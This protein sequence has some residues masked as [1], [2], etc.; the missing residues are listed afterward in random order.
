MK[1]LSLLTKYR[2]S[3]DFHRIA[4]LDSDIQELRN[5]VRKFADQSVAPL[6]QKVD[7]EDKFPHH[8]WK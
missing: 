1:A 2:F 8:L 7:K 3:T 5:I 4:N 6:A